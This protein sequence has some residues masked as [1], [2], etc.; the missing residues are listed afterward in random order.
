MIEKICLCVHDSNTKS[1]QWFYQG[2]NVNS[3]LLYDITDIASFLYTAPNETVYL[4]Y[5]DI[6]LPPLLLVP[7]SSNGYLQLMSVEKLAIW[8][9]K[10][11]HV[12]KSLFKKYDIK[13][14][15]INTS[16]DSFHCCIDMKWGLLLSDLINQCEQRK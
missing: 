13:R 14:A 7:V 10:H 1:I 11:Y 6:N 3:N 12:T 2:K 5:K 16:F 9:V 15:S 4:T 8:C